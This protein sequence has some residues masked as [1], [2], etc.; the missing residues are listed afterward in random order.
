[1]NKILNI[2]LKSNENGNTKENNNNINFKNNI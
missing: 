1:M 2:K